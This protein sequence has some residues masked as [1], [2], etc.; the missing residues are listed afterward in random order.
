MPPKLSNKAVLGHHTKFPSLIISSVISEDSISF[1][2]FLTDMTQT[3]TSNW[4]TEEV[5]GRNDPIGTFQNTTRTLSLSW[6][7]PSATEADA[8]INLTNTARLAQFLYPGY[9]SMSM[10]SPEL[11]TPFTEREKE[12]QQKLSA[13]TTQ[14][15]KENITEAIE[16][17]KEHAL[18][19][20][21]KL[22]KGGLAYVMSA[23]KDGMSDIAAGKKQFAKVYTPSEQL[24]RAGEERDKLREP[25]RKEFNAARAKS[26]KKYMESGAGGKDSVI[27]KPP[28]CRIKFANIIAGVRGGLLGW[29]DSVTITPKI[30]SG[31]WGNSSKIYPKVISLS[32]SFN[33]LHEEA[34]GF[35]FGYNWGKSE[36]PFK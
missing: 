10:V 23:G 31:F 2:A 30:E 6:D 34:L 20:A 28:L 14:A 16:D 18:P 5:Y 32:L 7:L 24:Q 36:W 26:I 9:T 12:L 4:Q 13:I 22:L 25:L 3:F 15:A 27:S 1:P 8:K 21:K 33:V 29:V 19:A 11:S 35:N 17:T